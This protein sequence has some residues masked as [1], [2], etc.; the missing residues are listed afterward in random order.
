MHAMLAAPTVRPSP[1]RKDV[2]LGRW[3]GPLGPMILAGHGAGLVG[4]WFQGQKHCPDFS[5][6]EWAGAHEGSSAVIREAT[7]QLEAYFEGR[8]TTFDLPLDPSS[9]TEFQT[10]VWATL[11][12]IPFGEAITYSALSHLI[13]KPTAVRAVAAAVGRN[14]LSIVIPCHRVLG[15]NGSLTG[16]AGGLERKAALLEHENTHAK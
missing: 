7:S 3:D 10:A 5:G 14:P 8:L 15:S 13:N 16:Y 1:S 2:R 4:V 6:P 11:R 9:G 12:S